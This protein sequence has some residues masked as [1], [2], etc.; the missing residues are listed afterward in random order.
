MECETPPFVSLFLSAAVNTPVVMRVFMLGGGIWM[1]KEEQ[2]LCY[3]GEYERGDLGGGMCA[4]KGFGWCI[5]A[6][7][8]DLC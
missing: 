2:N 8:G 3:K 4:M 7:R 1:G 6:R 5:C